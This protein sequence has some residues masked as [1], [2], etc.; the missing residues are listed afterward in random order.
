MRIRPTW[1]LLLPLLTSC[2]K[3]LFTPEPAA[4]PASVFQAVWQDYKDHYG[5]T[6]FRHI[7]WDSLHAAYSPMVSTNSTE[8]ELY[9]ALTEMLAHTN[10]GHVQITTPGREHWYANTYFRNRTGDNLFDLGIVRDRYLDAGNR[11]EVEDAVLRGHIGDV[12]YIHFSHVAGNLTELDALL[13]NGFSGK[14]IIDLRHNEGGDFTFALNA[15]DRLTDV[16]LPVFSSR[17][18]NGTGPDDFTPWYHWQLDPDPRKTFVDAQLIVLVDRFTISAGERATLMLAALPGVQLMG[19]TTNGAL[20]T[21]VG[22]EM[23]NGWAYTIATQEILLP[24]GITW[25]GVGIPPHKVVINDPAALA[26][27]HDAVLDS[28]LALLR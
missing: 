20:S 22:R 27:G 2:E 18:K 4:D 14:L 9:L 28:A 7:N 16:S 10:D 21:M 1:L 15:F 24:S 13:D 26:A 23:A 3:V 25:E 17:T 11:F 6:T 12:G 5:P 8:E 19:D